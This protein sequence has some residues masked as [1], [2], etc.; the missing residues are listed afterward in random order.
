MIRPSL[1]KRNACILVFVLSLAWVQQVTRLGLSGLERRDRIRRRALLL[2]SGGGL[3]L[4]TL[5]EYFLLSRFAETANLSTP[6][7]EYPRP[8]MQRRRWL[9]LNGWWEWQE[10]RSAVPYG[11]PLL[12]RVLVPF[13]V[14]APLSGLGLGSASAGLVRM[15]YR[16]SF[17]LPA[18]WRDE[19]RRGGGVLLHLGAVEWHVAVY[20]NQ[21]AVLPTHGAAEHAGGLTPSSFDISRALRLHV[22]AGSADA[23]PLQWIEIQTSDTSELHGKPVGKQRAFP[24]GIWYTQVTGLWQSVWLEPVPPA[25]ISRLDVTP[26]LDMTP[27]PQTPTMTPTPLPQPSTPVVGGARVL[28]RVRVSLAAGVG[29]GGG[30]TVEPQPQKW[31]GSSVDVRLLAPSRDGSGNEGAGE[32]TDLPTTRDAAATGRCVLSRLPPSQHDSSQPSAARSAAWLAMEGGAAPAPSATKSTSE[33]LGELGCTAELSVARLVHGDLWS[34]ESPTLF[35]VVATLHRTS[36]TAAATSTAATSTTSTADTTDAA[37]RVRSYTA[38]R[39]IALLRGDGT[40]TPPQKRRRQQQQRGPA[41]NRTEPPQEQRTVARIALNGRPY[42]LAGMLDQGYWPDGLYTAPSDEAL[43]SDIVAAKALGF[44]LLRKHG[45]VEPARWYYH[46]DRLG[47][48]VWQDLPSPPA[49]TCASD[50]DGDLKKWQAETLLRQESDNGETDKTFRDNCTVDADA[51]Q[52][53]LRRI[54]EHLSWSPAVAHWIVFNEAWGQ[55]GPEPEPGGGGVGGGVDERDL[56]ARLVATVRR[57]D[58]TRLVTDASGWF[59]STPH[60]PPDHGTQS[61]GGATGATRNGTTNRTTKPQPAPWIDGRVR[62]CGG[63]G[64]G[65]PFC[66]DTIDVHAYPGPFPSLP[67]KMRWYGHGWWE[68]LRWGRDEHRA[69]VL[70]EFGGFKYR[71]AAAHTTADAGWGYVST[72]SCDEFVGNVTRAWHDAAAAR[73]SA[74]VYTQVSDVELELN[75]LLTY[76]RHLKCAELL[77]AELPPLLARLK[78]ERNA[79]DGALDGAAE[80]ARADA[81]AEAARAEAAKACDEFVGT[82]EQIA[83]SKAPAGEKHVLVSPA[84]A[85]HR[86]GLDCGAGQGPRRIGRGTV[87]T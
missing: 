65:D 7:P 83:A 6:L 46:A 77:R 80:G 72:A 43:A 76:D 42:F 74:A 30:S 85:K 75:G 29:R 17:A 63:G 70:G 66:G 71:A 19:L 5:R 62:R 27:T 56:T 54:V 18:Q 9:S 10:V 35:G 78:A 33:G 79:D 26:I 13:P 21:Q 60:A 39:H 3:D 73:L 34:P 32:G 1:T 20:V 69:S 49:L 38:F 48:L 59:L 24:R 41:P 31:V 8:Q 58:T 82:P 4:E 23:Q 25:F 55:R 68:A 86:W 84:V 40:A 53:S 37:D 61:N 87:D 15:R 57:L 67:H 14:E 51:L 81:E 11:Q 22:A 28:V 44:N 16:R 2:A 36:S 64:G 12:H 50:A 52:R 45:K 47:M